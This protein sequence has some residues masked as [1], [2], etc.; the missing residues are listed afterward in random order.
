MNANQATLSGF[1]AILLWSSLAVLTAVSGTLPPF[2]LLALS[3]AVGGVFGSLLIRRRGSLRQ[4]LR[5]PLP[6]LA[7][8]SLALFGYHALYFYA[9]KRAP[10]IEANLINY[11][12]PL[13]IVVFAAVLA[14]QT[15][16]GYQWF[17]TLLGF[18]AAAL[19]VTRGET[20]SLEA[21]FLSGY[22]AAL[23]AALIWAAYSVLNR[24]YSEVPSTAIVGPCLITAL[25]GGIAHLLFEQTVSLSWTQWLIVLGMGLGPVGGAF[26]LWDSGT[27]RGDLVLLGSLSYSAPLLSTALLVLFGQSRFHWSQLVALACLIVGAAL[28]SYRSVRVKALA[29]TQHSI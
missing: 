28:S 6:A 25:A 24:R 15:V 14:G 12:W 17:G 1:F 20:I 8:A 7:L 27:K 23:G 19:V 3:F 4:G 18:L 10:V 21:R 9:L 5:Q 2:Q 22:A 11:T 29:K 16:R 13:L 26:W